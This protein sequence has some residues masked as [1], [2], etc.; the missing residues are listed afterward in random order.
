MDGQK[1]FENAT[2]GRGFFP[3]TGEKTSVFKN[4]RIRVDGAIISVDN[5]SQISVE[6]IL[7]N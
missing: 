7:M 5:T 3:K 2:C 4:V 6:L 1:R